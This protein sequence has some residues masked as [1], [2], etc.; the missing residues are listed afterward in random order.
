MTNEKGW[1]LD[2]ELSKTMMYKANKI[3]ANKLKMQG[4][5]VIDI[6]YPIGSNLS[7]SVFYN[8]ERLILFP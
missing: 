7:Q 3:W 8:M 6:G 2:D 1:I 5:T 4:Y